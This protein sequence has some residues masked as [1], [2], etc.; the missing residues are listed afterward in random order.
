[1]AV[2]QCAVHKSLDLAAWPECS[3][4]ARSRFRCISHVR[5]DKSGVFHAGIKLQ[6]FSEDTFENPAP[7]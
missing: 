2:P 5:H 6:A 7:K 3:L 1:M 4:S